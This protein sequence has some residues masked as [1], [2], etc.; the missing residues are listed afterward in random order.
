MRSVTPPGSETAA[1][2]SQLRE[3][4]AAPQQDGPNRLGLRCTA[5][6]QGPKMAPIIL[7]PITPGSRCADGKLQG[8]GGGGHACLARPGGPRLTAAAPAYSCLQLLTAAYSCA[9]TAYSCAPT[10]YSCSHG[11]QLQPP[12][13]SPCCSCKPCRRSPP[14]GWVMAYSCNP[15]GESLLQL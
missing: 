15:C 13:E 4:R 10:A 3:M 12:V 1:A 11:L 2:R 5:R 9:P 7:V 6:A 14:S 8:P